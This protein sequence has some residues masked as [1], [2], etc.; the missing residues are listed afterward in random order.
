MLFLKILLFRIKIKALQ[1]NTKGLE[2]VRLPELVSES[3]LIWDN[4]KISIDRI[5]HGKFRIV[6]N[7]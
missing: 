2:M 4:T 3:V 5:K 7:L 1:Q 6:C